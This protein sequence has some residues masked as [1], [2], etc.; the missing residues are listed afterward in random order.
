MYLNKKL[1]WLLF[2]ITCTVASSAGFVF[3]LGEA[4]EWYNSLNYPSF[5][6]PNWLF[7]PVWSI[8]YIMIATSAY[9]L[10]YSD[11]PKTE[12]LAPISMGLWCIQIVLNTIWTPIFAGAQNLEVAFYYIMALWVSILLY[13]INTL[14]FNL[15]ASLL[16]FPY[17]CWVSFASVLNYSFWKLNI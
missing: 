2:F 6:P 11:H 15:K 14:F 10:V 5:T 4:N 12:K 1:V 3:P 8:L 9:L 13:I 7:G 16:M 17:F